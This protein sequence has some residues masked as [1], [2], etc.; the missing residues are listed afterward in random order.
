MDRR[1]FVTWLA[2]GSFALACAPAGA[3]PAPGPL[4]PWIAIAPDGR[5]TLT[6]TALEMGQGSRTGQAQVLADELE[7]HWDRIT[8]VQA[9]EV[10]P[11]L[12]DGAL[13]SGGSETLRS[14][15]E[16]LRRAGATA[17]AQLTEAAARRWNVAA[18]TCKAELGEV[19]HRSTGRR[20]DYGALAADAAL[21]APPKEPALKP[22]QQRRY[23][24]KPISTL[25][26]PTKLNGEARYG[27][28]FRLPGMAFATI[29]QCPT[30]GGTLASV[31][32]APARAVRGV[33]KVVK[34][35][36][37]VAVVATSTFAA[38]KGAKALDPRWTA[39]AGFSS[40]KVSAALE[41]GI[42]APD[43]IV[44]PREGGAATRDRLRAA[45]GPAPRK[46]EAAYEIA[47][48]SHAPLEPMNATARAD[49]TSAEIWAP[50]QSPTWLRD[51]VVAMTGLAK[52]KITVHPLLM[53]GGFGRRLKG[54][55]AARAVQVA[56]HLD[57][58]VQVVWTREED[59]AHDFYRPAMRMMLR[60][61]LGEDGALAGYEVLATTADD[62][63]GGSGAK[64]YALASAATLATAKVGVPVGAWRAVDPGMALFA[65][66]SFIDECAHLAGADPLAYR[67]AMLG[68]NE[69]A[70]RALQAVARAIGWGSP[71]APGVGRGLALL[72]EW[73][74]VVAHAVEVKVVGNRLQVT[75][76]VAAA[77]VGLAVNPQQV[78][79]QF[80]GGGLMA[81]S[82]ALGEQMTFTDGRADQANF[83]DYPILRM[84]QAPPVQVILLETPDV[85]LGGAG[86]PPVPGVAP[87]LANAIFQATG[88][89]VRRL[90]FVTQGFEV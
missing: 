16:L 50:C 55:Y 3:S 41:A 35:K 53:G 57:G 30:F 60:A 45:Y 27:I 70:R 52:E 76:L 28:D 11:F 75:R 13:Y 61:A 54:D 71:R 36:D 74:T 65:K 4:S 47:Y 17:R 9:G 85:P 42:D 48:L 87:A 49:A 8:V 22:A 46:H 78:R 29:R 24:G 33:T 68:K 88:K 81:L 58:P 34:L 31:D 44:S 12:S 63:T 7:A 14:R 18:T 90:P 66:E 23:I 51:D 1:E 67:D 56:Q 38:F 77:D 37:A 19:I 32:E 62:R 82:A 39:P 43:A 86:E 59:M 89:R 64:P 72:E 6:S 73:D 79:A 2:G 5:I 15:F 20:L 84:R 69:R 40:A 10:E 25:A 26:Q 21:C 80:E 83:G